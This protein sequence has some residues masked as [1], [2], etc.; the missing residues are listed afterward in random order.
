MRVR[1]WDM[2]ETAVSEDV[3]KLEHCQCETFKRK[4]IL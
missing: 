4:S 1:G 2:A 3:I